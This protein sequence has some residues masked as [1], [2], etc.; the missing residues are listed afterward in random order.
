M[1]SALIT[2]INGFTGPYVKRALLQHG[3]AVYGT[4]FKKSNDPHILQTDLRI[5]DSVEHTVNQINPDIVIHLAGSTSPALQDIDTVFS[6]NAVC[7]FNLLKSLHDLRKKPKSILICSSAHVYSTKNTHDFLETSPIEPLSYYA[8]SK[9]VVESIAKTWEKKLP[10]TI[11]RPFNY[12][13]P[14]QTNRYLIPKIIDHYARRKETIAL[15][16]LDISRDYSDVRTVSEVYAKLAQTAHPGEIFNICSGKSHT[17]HQIIEL[18]NAIA[19][20]EIDITTSKDHIR[21]NDIKRICGSNQKLK[22]TIG[23]FS[24]IPLHE[25]LRW[26]YQHRIAELES[27]T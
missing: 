17:L 10:I 11:I 2:G 9:L 6:A 4:S 13:G 14:G 3:L 25:T 26:M 15:G 1:K 19:G 21:P 16:N 7:T 20:Y 23:T 18:M 24:E 5:P 8:K 27:T 22:D 12:T